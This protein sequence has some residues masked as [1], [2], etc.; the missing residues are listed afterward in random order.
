MFLSRL[1]IENYRSIEKCDLKF[2]S[3]KNVIVGRNNSGKSNILKAI[4]I[5][6]GEYSPTYGK[7]DSIS[8]NDFHDGNL[9]LPI[10]M[11]CEIQREYNDDGSLE[12]ISFRDSEKSA[13][14]RLY[15][16][17]AK[18]TS[19]RIHV[20]NFT[21]QEKLAMFKFNSDRADASI[22]DLKLSKKYI[23]GRKYCSSTFA[24]EFADKT[25]FALAFYA[26]KPEGVEQLKKELVCFYREDSTQ[27]WIIGMNCNIRNALLQSAI[28]PA[29]RDPKDQLRINSYT[30]FGKLLKSYVNTN[31]SDLNKA[32]DTVKV[33][34][35]ELFKTL[36]DKVSENEIN[37]AFPN[38]T[39]SFQFN[40]DTK[41]DIHKS[42]LIYVN[43]GFNSELKDKGAG[44]QSA[45]TISL[46]DF[47]VRNVAHDCSS[48]LAVEEPELY[49]HPHGRRVIANKLSRFIKHGKNQVIITTHSPEF[50]SNINENQ[51]I[52]SVRKE[53]KATTATN[54]SFNTPKRKQILVK[55]QNAELFFA[56]SVILTEGADKYFIEE[57]ARCYAKE[58]TFINQE[59]KDVKLDYNWLNDYNISVINCGGKHELWKYAEIL[60]DLSIHYVT[61]A[62]F[63]F[64]RDGLNT[65]LH[66]V[67]RDQ[68]ALDVLNA[69]KSKVKD[70]YSKGKFKDLEE[71]QNEGLKNEIV[72]FIEFLHGYN[73]FLFTGELEKFYKIKPALDKEGGVIE[74]IGNIIET[75][76]SISE[77][78]DTTEYY[79]VF[80]AIVEKCIGY[81]EKFSTEVAEA[82]TL[83]NTHSDVPL[84]LSKFKLDV[85]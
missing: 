74:T 10:F 7:S 24:T 14:V 6:L 34:S 28:I 65:Y 33:A 83:S 44:I 36:R 79:P 57:A 23:G 38:T 41:Q 52:L 43:D 46:F 17:P 68:K 64:L 37:I 19:H 31:S 76:K 51:N 5:L 40:P 21:K 84:L 47:Y 2:D 60:K 53:G 67:H 42:T 61:T 18:T 58:T 3:G 66:E 48:L 71:I 55:K 9:K 73:V 45:V 59:V 13:Y 78:F 75:G 27:D 62:D 32:F 63:D 72:S 12:P 25:S 20:S 16:D 29:F 8:E 82:V 11:W 49:L 54:I 85:T 22:D 77:F 35:N 30:W 80:K 26:Y 81:K 4:D 70:S 1:Y 15:Q 39:I 69:L 56:D 50:I